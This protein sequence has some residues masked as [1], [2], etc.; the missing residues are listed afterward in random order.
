MIMNAF[1]ITGRMVSFSRLILTT[2]NQDEIRKQLSEIAKNSPLINVPV[3]IDSTVEQELIE[4]IQL[5][6]AEGLQPIAVI[7]G[8]LAEQARDIQFPVLPKDRPV[9]RIKAT[10]EQMTL[11]KTP[12]EEPV[13]QAVT[14]TP[15]VES[16][17]EADTA[18]VKTIMMEHKTSFHQTMLRTGQALVQ[19]Y[20][21]IILTAGTNSGSE[22]IASGN[23]HVYGFA[24]GRLIAGAAGDV[25]AKIFCHALNSELVSIAGVYCL[26][27][28]IPSRVIGR[29]CYIYLNEQQELCFDLLE[30]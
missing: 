2:D 23:I 19:E 10:D 11:V 22:V 12:Q 21:D 8:V 27:D 25:H 20:G 29:P 16:K 4:I 26:A 30:F 5:L 28:D 14:D 3:V 18:V 6:L 15:N 13:V 7:E 1:K 9:E 24:R 17:P